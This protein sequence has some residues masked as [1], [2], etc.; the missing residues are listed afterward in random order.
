MIHD[1]A[2]YV[3]FALTFDMKR[4]IAV[5]ILTKVGVKPSLVLLVAVIQRIWRCLSSP[6]G[7]EPVDMSENRSSATLRLY[8]LGC[9]FRGS[10][11]GSNQVSLR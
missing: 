1:D 9:V 5:S 8:P 3:L 10:T 4:H 11:G 6:V 7:M 2:L